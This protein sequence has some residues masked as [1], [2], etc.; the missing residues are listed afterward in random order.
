VF[1]VAV[2]VA[3]PLLLWFGRDHWFF[4]DDWWVLTKDGIT[5]PG[6]L[7]GH[8]GHWITLVRFTHRVTFEVFGLGPYLPYQIPVVLA[9]LGA[10]VLARQVMLRLGVRGWIA[11]AAALAFLFFGSGREDIVWGHEVGQVMSVVC[12]LALLLLADGPRHLTRRDWLCLGIGLLGL[13]SSAMFVGYLAGFGIATLMRRGVRVT[14]FH[15][16]PLGVIY[17]AWYLRYGAETS[18]AGLGIVG[19]VVRFVANMFWATFDALA[20]GGI[21]AV[22]VAMAVVGL[23]AAVHRGWRAGSWTDAAL[24]LG[25]AVAWAA[26]AG[27][28][29]MARANALSGSYASTRYLYVGAALLLPLAAAGVEQLAKRRTIVGAAALIP[30]AVGLPG[31]IDELAH[32]PPVFRGN[33]EVVL[34]I[35][36]QG[37]IGGDDSSIVVRAGSVDIVVRPIRGAG[38]AKLCDPEPGRSTGIRG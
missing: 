28:T 27:M 12:G 22:L 31:N 17:L 5:G 36:G 16:L 19:A 37:F 34:T 29:A 9:H 23:G 18:A 25:L 24:P 32:T 6:Y 8:N 30:L 1:A 13:T 35:G 14:A 4:L 7:D 26:A 20:Q 38:P 15:A 2:V 33:R 11:T 21:G 10:V 3:L